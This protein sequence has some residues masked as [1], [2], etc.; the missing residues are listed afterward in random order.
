VIVEGWGCGYGWYVWYGIMQ[1]DKEIW[2]GISGKEGGE[3][4]ER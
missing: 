3:M 2:R 1:K 4:K